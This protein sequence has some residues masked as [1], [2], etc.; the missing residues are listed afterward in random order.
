MDLLMA[1]EINFRK[2]LRRWPGD[3]VVDRLL[4]AFLNA[5]LALLPLR[6]KFLLD[7]MLDKIGLRNRY[8]QWIVK[9][10]NYG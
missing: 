2:R 10:H 4:S 5:P 3:E 8:G 7:A 9:K 1:I 6:T